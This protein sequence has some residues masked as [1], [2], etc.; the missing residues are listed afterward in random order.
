MTFESCSGEERGRTRLA[1]QECIELTSVYGMMLRYVRPSMERKPKDSNMGAKA[2]TNSEVA[3]VVRAAGT[4]PGS[5]EG[6]LIAGRWRT[7]SSGSTVLW[8]GIGPGR[9]QA[10]EGDQQYCNQ[11]G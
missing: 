5:H 8:R 1:D 10:A 3:Q 6:G 2:V 9:N 11:L 7:G 4:V